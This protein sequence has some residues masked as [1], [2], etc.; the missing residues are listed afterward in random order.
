MTVQPMKLFYDLEEGGGWVEV[1]NQI[2]TFPTI[3]NVMDTP[4]MSIVVLNDFEG[5]LKATWG[6]RDFTLI[7]IEDDSANIIFQG[8][9]TNK[10]YKENE[11]SFIIV[12]FSKAFEWLRFKKDYILAEGKI[13]AIN[14]NKIT[15]TDE[16]DANFNWDV[17]YWITE[18]NDV[19]LMV[20]DNTKSTTY[21]TWNADAVAVVRGGEDSL[22][23][24]E[25]DTTS[26]DDD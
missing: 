17:D 20:I 26:K 4:D 16:D 7:K 8:Y 22:G 3:D 2:K 19:G 5:A 13:T 11:G 23:G 25:T 12:G 18:E 15:V 6:S 1:Q 21:K 24:N 9:L 10:L 14:F